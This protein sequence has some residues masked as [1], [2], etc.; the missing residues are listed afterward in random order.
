MATFEGPLLS[1]KSVSALAH[2]TDWIIGHV[3]TGALGWNGLMAAGM[4]YWLVPRLFRTKLHS[5]AMANAH[6]WLA[7]LGILL[8]MVSMW[9]AGVTQGLMLRATDGDGVLAYP[10]F[11]E[12]LVAIRGTYYAR[13]TGGTMYLVGMILMAFN[14]A[15]TA[16]SGEAVDGTA[17]VVEL[18]PEKDE[19]STGKLLLARPLILVALGTVSLLGIGLARDVSGSVLALALVCGLGVATWITYGD[20]ETGK[21]PWHRVLEGRSLIFSGLTLLAVLV[22]SV[23]ELVPVV[24][25]HGSQADPK[26]FPPYKPLELEGRDIYVRE[27]C[28]TCHSQ[29]IRPFRHEQL[30][31][32]APSELEESAW[33]HPFQWGSRRTGPDLA[34]VGTKYPNLWHYKHMMDPR[35]I[36]PAS[37]MPTYAFLNERPIDLPLISAKVG[38]M[39]SLGVPYSDAE[40]QGAQAAAQTQATAIAADLDKQGVK[41]DPNSQMVALIAYLQRLGKPETQP[42]TKPVAQTGR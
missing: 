27:G 4:F 25:V 21:G 8:Y 42:A 35:S 23:A 17:T 2:Y 19:P 30:R 36:A 11:I 7:T 20:S 18:V 34:R 29:M 5:V 37:I 9:A 26:K 28:Y 41:V 15:K 22:G 40:V 31:Y 3:H 1:I 24:I 33:D 16:L 12:T 14:L 38:A 6:F 32:G 13:L 39:K 10:D